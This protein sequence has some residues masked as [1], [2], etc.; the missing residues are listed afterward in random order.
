MR[1]NPINFCHFLAC[2]LSNTTSFLS[3]LEKSEWLK[4][5]KAVIDT[6]LFISNAIE[7]NVNVVVHCSDGWDR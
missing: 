7:S 2:E 6:S 4:H 1:P 3:N 5:I